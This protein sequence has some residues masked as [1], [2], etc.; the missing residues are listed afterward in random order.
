MDMKLH[1]LQADI[2]KKI[3]RILDNPARNSM[4]NEIIFNHQEYHTLVKDWNFGP[5]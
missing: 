4:S 2:H 3:S 5:Q 1:F